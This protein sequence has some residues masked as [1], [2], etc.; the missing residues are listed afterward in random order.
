[1]TSGGSNRFLNFLHSDKHFAYAFAVASFVLATSGLRP[2][3]IRFAFALS[4]NAQW[5]VFFTPRAL[6]FSKTRFT[7]LR[8]LG[9]SAESPDPNFSLY[10]MLNFVIFA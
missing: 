2:A 7:R 4:K 8:K 9:R 6:P 3:K 1:M 5:F 10:L